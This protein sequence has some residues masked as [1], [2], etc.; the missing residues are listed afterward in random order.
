MGV[1]VILTQNRMS[2]HTLEIWMREVKGGT[3]YDLDG[4]RRDSRSCNRNKHGGPTFLGP[5]V[6]VFVYG[7]IVK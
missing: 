5:V 4:S 3:I 1:G 2:I 7:T 6:T